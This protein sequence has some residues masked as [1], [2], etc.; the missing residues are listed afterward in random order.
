MN[1]KADCRTAPATPGLL[2]RRGYA[3]L[4][5]DSPPRGKKPHERTSIALQFF[6]GSS[7]QRNFAYTTYLIVSLPCFLECLDYFKIFMIIMTFFLD[8]L[9]K[10]TN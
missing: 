5:T 1:H 2:T 6:L 7:L 4:I 10:K 9:K 8:N 3:L